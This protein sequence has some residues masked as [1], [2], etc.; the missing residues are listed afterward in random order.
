MTLNNFLDFKKKNHILLSLPSLVLYYLAVVTFTGVSYGLIYAFIAALL[1]L[2]YSF[3]K[4]AL[5][6]FILSFLTFVLGRETEA[7]HYLSFVYGFLFIYL[8]KNLYLLFKQHL[9]NG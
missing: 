5:I 7:N 2:R 6:F 1:L 4:I 8:L 9:T 3:V